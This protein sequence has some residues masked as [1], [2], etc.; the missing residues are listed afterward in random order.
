MFEW[1]FEHDSV[2]EHYFISAIAD[3]LMPLPQPAEFGHEIP[4][5][6]I[7]FEY[8]ECN[9]VYVSTIFFNDNIYGEVKSGLIFADKNLQYIGEIFAP[10][11]WPSV[12]SK[13]LL[14]D[15]RHPNDSIVRINYL[16]LVKTDRDYYQ[17]IDSF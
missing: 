6:Y 1:D 17:Y 15:I 9:Q 2:I 11:Q 4:H 16:K 8:D 3:S 13:D 14:L 7:G 10:K 5:R 12:S